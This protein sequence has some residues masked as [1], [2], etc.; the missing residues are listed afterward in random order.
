MW[1]F[2]LCIVLQCWYILFFFYRVF[3]QSKTYENTASEVV[4]IIICAKNEAQNIANN[5]PGILEQIYTNDSGSVYYEVIVVDDASTDDT[6]KVL[7]NLQGKYVHLR[8]VTL[9]ASGFPAADGKK[10][11]LGHGVEAARGTWLLLTDADCRPASNRWLWL[12]TRPLAEGKQIVAGY[13]GMEGGKGL[14]NAFIRWETMHTYMQYSTY[15]K[16]GFPYMAVGR[17]MACTK[18]AFE[19]AQQT[20]VW[21]LLPSGDDD[22]MVRVVANKNNMAVVQDAGAFTYS[23]AKESWQEW[24]AQKQRHVSTGKLYKQDVKL[25]LGVY[26]LSH[27]IVWGMFI[28]LL[29]TPYYQQVLLLFAL[30]C[31]LYWITEAKVTRDIHERS[32]LFWIPVCDIGWAIYNFIF[33]PYI[34]WKNKRQWK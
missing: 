26:A 30:R 20:P 17:N 29:F 5:L 3:Q 18:A 11:A 19:Q 27:A 6:G 31:V 8:V 24:A 7:R 16:A 4:S 32:L 22:L 21:N 9:L 12:M 2:V 23:A 10:R 13:G 34:F 25:L 33:A 1:L 28:G 15:A 14:L